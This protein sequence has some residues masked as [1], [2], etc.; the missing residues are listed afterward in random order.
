MVV[1][2]LNKISEK[3]VNKINTFIDS[4]PKSY[5]YRNLLTAKFLAH[6]L[7]LSI[8]FDLYKEKHFDG[9]SLSCFK[10]YSYNGL[11]LW[12]K[13]PHKNTSIRCEVYWAK[14][15]SVAEEELNESVNRAQCPHKSCFTTK[16][17]V[18]EYTTSPTIEMLTFN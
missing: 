9:A 17:S 13:K 4:L 8:L 2:G 11:N 3:N 6:N 18:D 1:G 16:K 15:K 5:Y 14:K 10:T 12:F 7:N